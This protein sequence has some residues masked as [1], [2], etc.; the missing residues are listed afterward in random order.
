MND[1]EVLNQ[2]EID[3]LLKGVDNGA[4]PL[5]ANAAEPGE[6]RNYDLATQV[7]IVRG[8][9]P[10]LEMIND[11]FARL[12]R[13]G[14]YNLIRRSPEIAVAPVNVIKFSE[15]VQTLHLP[16]SLNLVKLNP[17]RG[18]G[19]FVLDATLVFAI[20]DSFFGG[21]GRHAKIEGREFT[22]TENRVIQMV[23]KQVFSDF[24]EAWGPVAKLEV[25]YL[26]SEINPHF[27]NIVSPS[28][29]VV[30]TSFRIEL[31]GGGGELH[32]TMPYSMIEP[33]RDVLD[34]GMQSDRAERDESWTVTMREE[35]EEAEVEIVPVI[36]RS[37]V[38]VGRLLN[39]KPGD[40]IPCDFAGSVTLVAEGVPILRGSYGASRGQQAVK[41]EK[42]LARNRQQTASN[43]Q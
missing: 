41:I 38:T 13:I 29:I 11:R 1:A 39:L 16:A 22:Q 24:H 5:E 28:E 18:T 12:M 21:S 23:L 8:R 42:H 25:E 27:A 32:V 43:R 15:Y 34:S 37:V 36:G 9:M 4:V 7:R 26:N 20:V 35:I 3:A 40:V 31:D 33:L 6:A 19:L 10:T 17:L 30:V 14:L 2:D